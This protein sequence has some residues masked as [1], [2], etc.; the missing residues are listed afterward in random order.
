MTEEQ[1]T[2]GTEQT[3]PLYVDFLPS[4]AGHP[5][6]REFAARRAAFMLRMSQSTYARLA[7]N[8]EQRRPVLRQVTWVW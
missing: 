4:H 2:K 3:I 8:E 1:E 6:G 7:F 5:D